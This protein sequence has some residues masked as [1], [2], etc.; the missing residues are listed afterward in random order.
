MGFFVR[1][2]PR[3]TWAARAGEPQVLSHAAATTCRVRIAAWK[4]RRGSAKVGLNGTFRAKFQR[5]YTSL[6]WRFGVGAR[7]TLSVVSLCRDQGELT[8]N[9]PVRPAV[10]HWVSWSWTLASFAAVHAPRRTVHG[11]G[12]SWSWTSASIAPEFGAAVASR[13][14]GDGAC[15]VRDV[16]VSL[17]IPEGAAHPYLLLDQYA[18]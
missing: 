16:R 7:E 3:G 9:R 8:D 6:T 5:L 17:P 1:P 13:A 11:N 18:L 10:Y 14:Q 12:V 4:A 2:V 15:G